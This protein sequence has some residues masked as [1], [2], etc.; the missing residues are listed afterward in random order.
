M[1][2]L[3]PHPCKGA[4]HPD[5]HLIW[6]V[7]SD[8]PCH[9]ALPPSVPQ[10]LIDP[11]THQARSCLG[12]FAQPRKLFPQIS[13]WLFLTTSKS[14]LKY[15]FPPVSNCNLSPSSPAMTLLNL[16]SQLYFFPIALTVF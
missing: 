8:L 2:R 7:P 5:P 15:P 11:R 12:A 4:Q 16:L 6:L 10:P 13:T 3:C 14:L 1:A 9:H